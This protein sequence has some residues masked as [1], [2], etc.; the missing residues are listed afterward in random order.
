MDDLDIPLMQPAARAAFRRRLLAWFAKYARDLPWRRDRDAYK[1]WVS[2]VML[3]QTQVATVAGY[4]ERFVRRFPDAASL[5][6]AKL[7]LPW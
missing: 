5:A 4:F 1:V 7:G 6:A 2:E 3:Q